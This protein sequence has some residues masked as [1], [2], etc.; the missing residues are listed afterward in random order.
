MQEHTYTLLDA[1]NFQKLEQVGSFR[2]IRPAPQAA[3]RAELPAKEWEQVDATFTRFSGGKGRW[4]VRQKDMPAQWTIDVP[5]GTMVLKR[6]SFG[7]IG[8]FAEQMTYWKTLHNL[9][10][11]TVTQCGECRVLN[12]FA[13]TGGS[14]LACAAGGASIVHVDA[15]KP[16]VAWARENAAASHLEDASIRWIVDDVQKFAAREVRRKSTYHGII[17]D[18]PSYGRGPQGQAWN[19]E[20]NLPHLLQDLARLLDTE[21]S[22]IHLSAHSANF[23]ALVLEN[24]LRAYFPTSS[25]TFRTE[26]M[27]IP[28][29]GTF[30]LPSGASSLF[31]RIPYGDQ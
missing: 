20:E 5:V 9:T 22:F 11:H 27:L 8:M 6:S 28:S 15:S 30:P 3:W 17:L 26:E 1:G 16:T 25:G 10:T 7:H 14:T 13:Y 23:S 29:Q 21:F 24:C 4:D 12:L 31:S 2:M 19:I 18:P